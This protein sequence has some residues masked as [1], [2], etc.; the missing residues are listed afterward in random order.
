MGA[1]LALVFIFTIIIMILEIPII[2]PILKILMFIGVIGFCVLFYQSYQ[3]IQQEKADRAVQ[4]N[5]SYRWTLYTFLTDGEK[6]MKT[7]Y[8]LVF[9]VIILHSNVLLAYDSS[10]KDNS[11]RTTGYL[12]KQSDRTYYV[13]KKGRRGNYIEEDGTIKD[14]KGRRIGSMD[15][16]GDRTYYKDNYGRR[17]DYIDDDGYIKDKYGRR[18]GKIE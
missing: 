15:Q 1:A 10:I 17:G 2:G 16:Q 7:I 3:N 6:E 11:G 13:D 9:T 12:D 4:Y 14:S 5:S 8:F 18:K